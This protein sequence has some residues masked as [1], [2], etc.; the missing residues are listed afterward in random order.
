M[1]PEWAPSGIKISDFLGGA[2]PLTASWL[3]CLVS[4]KG[5]WSDPRS[6]VSGTTSAGTDVQELHKRLCMEVEVAHLAKGRSQ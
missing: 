6:E 1:C 2:S 5:V 3:C 4:R